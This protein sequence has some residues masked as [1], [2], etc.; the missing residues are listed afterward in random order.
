VCDALNEAARGV[1]A[2]EIVSA[3][4]DSATPH[5]PVRAGQLLVVTGD[6]HVVAVTDAVDGTCDVVL[7]TLDITHAEVV[8]V[9]VG[10]D[11]Q[12]AEVATL[13]RAFR[14]RNEAI[15]IDVI[16]G[17]VTPARF[18]IGAE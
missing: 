12:A 7:A 4:R 16:D 6:G 2:V 5:G 1:R 8:T 9:L 13:E 10:S 17:G 14:A 15:D 18:W 3:I 11:A